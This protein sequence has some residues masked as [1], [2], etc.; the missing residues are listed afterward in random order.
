MRILA[1]ILI[2]AGIV[3]GLASF[4][5]L[6][7]GRFAFR[8]TSL[9]DWVVLKAPRLISEAFSCDFCLCWWICLILSL[10]SAPFFGWWA[11]ISA[12]VATPVARALVA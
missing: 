12:P 3:C 1:E 11:V 4:I 10:L 6:F 2:L 8:G 7:L 9:R 5:V